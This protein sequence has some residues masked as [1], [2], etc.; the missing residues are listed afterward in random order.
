MKKMWGVV[1]LISCYLA[2]CQ[3]CMLMRVTD[4]KAQEEFLAHGLQPKFKSVIVNGSP[5]H[6]VKIGEDN[7]PTL[8][9]VHGSPGSWDAYKQYLMNP[10]LLKHFRIIAIDRPGFGFSSFGQAFD[11]ADQAKLIYGIVK[12]EQNHQKLHLI[13]HSLG[14][15]IIVKLAQ[16]NPHI[17]TSLTILAGSISP[18]DEPK[19]QW[20]YLLVNTPLRY[21]LPGA[22]RTSNTEIYYFKKDLYEMDAHYDR[23]GL[24]ITFIHGDKD[25]LVTVK[26]VAY[27]QKKLYF[28]KKVKTIIIPGANHFIPWEHFDLIKDHLLSLT[29]MQ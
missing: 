10:D 27:G 20:R 7:L 23:L 29:K 3:S 19:E 13:G 12:I 8:F 5:L 18:Y 28:N 21:L 17:Y 24:P 4:Q 25:P 26:N 15:P 11:L 2:F 6:Y 16:D 9:F 1:F 14:G 22:F